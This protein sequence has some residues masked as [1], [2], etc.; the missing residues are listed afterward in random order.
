QL[1]H[2][3][4]LHLKQAHKHVETLH[5]PAERLLAMLA[6]ENQRLRLRCAELEQRHIDMIGVYE[7]SMTVEHER[8]LGEIATHAS[9]ERK[10]EVLRQSAAAAAGCGAGFGDG[11]GDPVTT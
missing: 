1:L 10:Q 8:K 3:A 11:R 4:T 5:A 6:E 9:E 2:Q 7:R